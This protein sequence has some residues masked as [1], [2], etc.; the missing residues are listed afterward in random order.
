M[1]DAVTE[2]TVLPVA[3]DEAWEL[4]SD[5]RHLGAWLGADV[6]IDLREGGTL[7]VTDLDGRERVGVVDEV[8]TGERLRFR[9]RPLGLPE[10]DP[11]GVET[12]V[13]IAVE[14]SAEGTRVRVCESGLAP[15]E[16]AAAGVGAVA[17]WAWS[18]RL[19]VLGRLL[20]PVP[21]CR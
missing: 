15:I 11:R 2:E 8:C 9:W 12:T 19:A 13:E 16:A 21:A 14:E 6:A 17:G 5:P 3:P 18:S 4:V 10:S 20:V 7:R 1:T